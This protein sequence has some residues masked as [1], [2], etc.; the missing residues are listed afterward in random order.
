MFFLWPGCSSLNG[1]SPQQPESVLF[2]FRAT[3]SSTTPRPSCSRLNG[4]SL[5]A[6]GNS[7]PIR[8]EVEA[9]EIQAEG[10]LWE[11]SVVD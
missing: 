10:F 4:A 11:V 3:P 1:L 7:D 6:D 2:C 8:C 5:L 9:C